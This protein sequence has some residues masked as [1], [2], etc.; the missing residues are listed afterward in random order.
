[1]RERTARWVMERGRWCFNFGEMHAEM[2]SLVEALN[3]DRAGT[4]SLSSIHTLNEDRAQ[5]IEL[6]RSSHRAVKE[7]P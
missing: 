2:M 4:L 6:C 7:N 1:M 3:E 5:Y